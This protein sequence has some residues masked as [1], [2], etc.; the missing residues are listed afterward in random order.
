MK[1]LDL[2]I[3]VLTEPITFTNTYFVD[4]K[5]P[6]ELREKTWFFIFRLPNY[7]VWTFCVL[8][9]GIFSPFLGPAS[10]GFLIAPLIYTSACYLAFFL[11]K[12]MF[13]MSM[14]WAD[15]H[16]SEEQSTNLYLYTI[17]ISF[18]VNF[19]AWISIGI[20][21]SFLLSSFPFAGEGIIGAIKRIC[22]PY[23]MLIWVC[24]EIIIYRVI[25][26]TTQG[27]SKIE[28]FVYFILLR[29]CLVM[30]LFFVFVVILVVILMSSLYFTRVPIEESFVEILF[31][32]GSHT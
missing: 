24:T 8:A 32:L 13:Q 17:L 29:M 16:M 5:T 23:Q 25:Q 31:H 4:T 9:A 30:A 10:L 18:Y 22:A 15:L 6:E 21:V 11:G 27:L 2:L 19:A 14:N 1:Y 7:F 12:K 28:Y 26:K 20:L 3:K